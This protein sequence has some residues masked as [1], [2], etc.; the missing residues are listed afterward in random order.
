MKV[1][2]AVYL[3]RK[4]VFI[5]RKDKN[6]KGGG[7]AKV[8]ITRRLTGQ[9]GENPWV[10]SEENKKDYPGEERRNINYSPKVCHP[11]I[12]VF[13]PFIGWGRHRRQPRLKGKVKIYPP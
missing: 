6:G 5:G 3:I 8:T 7:M 13:E 12:Q 9:Q 1:T 11:E 10:V 2:E 4:C